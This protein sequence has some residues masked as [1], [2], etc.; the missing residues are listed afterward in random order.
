LIATSIGVI[1]A[2]HEYNDSLFCGGSINL[3][4]GSI[5]YYSFSYNGAN[6]DLHGQQLGGSGFR[7]FVTINDTLW[8]VGNGLSSANLGLNSHV[9]SIAYR[10]SGRWKGHNKYSVNNVKEV[11]A[12][13]EF[14]G[15]L[16]L[17]GNFT[18]PYQFV[19]KHNGNNFSP[20]GSGFDQGVTCMAVY[21]GELYAGGTISL[22]G[23]TPL[24]NVA[25]WNG[26]SWEDV[27]GGTDLNVFCMEV[28]NGELYIGGVFTNAGGQPAS[29]LARW[30]GN[31]WQSLNAGVSSSNGQPCYVNV[32]ES[33]SSGLMIGGRFEMVDGVAGTNLA[34]WNGTSLTAYGNLQINEEVQAIGEYQNGLYFSTFYFGPLPIGRLY[35]P[36]PVGIEQ[37]T[38]TDILVFPNPS[39]TFLSID[40]TDLIGPIHITICSLSGQLLQEVHSIGGRQINIDLSITSGSYILEVQEEQGKRSV[41]RIVVE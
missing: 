26:T 5:T 15:D 21:N 41:Q 22:S 17:G 2:L 19:A 13:E 10:D 14:Q 6:F 30:D 31:V 11:L 38:R 12:L 33:T 39:A 32:L 18:L 8:G 7:D 40:A 4:N 3:L 27:G 16:I 36:G 37:I 29:R 28:W 34:L 25:K 24:S 9:N 35:G 20:L 1:H 23:A